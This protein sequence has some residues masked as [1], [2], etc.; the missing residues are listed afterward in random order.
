[1][2]NLERIRA[3]REAGLVE[4]CHV[5]PHLRSYNNAQHTWGVCCLLHIFWPED[6]HLVTFALFHDV[7]ER[8][9][10]DVPAQVL[11]ANPALKTAFAGQDEMIM[12]ALR[13]PCEH[14][15]V[16]TDFVRFKACDRLEFWLWTWEEEA[17]G[18]RMVLNAREEIES[19]MESDP[20]TPPEILN[21][22]DAYAE[23]GF[24]RH[25]EIF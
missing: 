13:L 15:L 19:H 23:G 14:S 2:D 17:L 21:F 9:T 10:G 18:N 8:W 24:Q 3:L 4:R 25:R 11:R 5:L 1:M 22:M 16:D 12:S 7:P 20:H 6:P